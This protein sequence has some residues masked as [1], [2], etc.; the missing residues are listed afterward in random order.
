MSVSELLAPAS[1]ASATPTASGQVV[2]YV[3]VS[4]ADQNT[5]RQHEAIGEVSRVFE[6][7]ISGK[8]RE[9]RVEL[10]RMIEWVRDGD[11]I[12][13]ASF[14][15]LARSLADLLDIVAEVNGKGAS[16]HFVKEHLTFA[17]GD[18]DPYARFQMQV[19]GAAAELERNLIRERQREGIALAR[20][21]GAYRGRRPVLGAEQIESAKGLLGQGVPLT[22][23]A[24]GLDVS[25]SSLYRALNGQ[26]TYAP[27]T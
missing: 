4:S 19:L 26:G 18:T 7:R 11:L 23:V 8:S 9:P 24:R 10:A 16:V 21:R 17:P 22:K 5:A 14:D 20:Q 25:R 27:A 13:V 15:R 1:P 6:D 2:G 3:R 12:K